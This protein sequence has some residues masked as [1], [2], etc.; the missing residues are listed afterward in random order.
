MPWFLLFI[1]CVCEHASI[2]NL[3]SDVSSSDTR[4]APFMSDGADH[5][6]RRRGPYPKGVQRRQEILERTLDVFAERGFSGTSLRA[7]GE[8]IGVSH[9]ALGHYFDSREALLVEVLRE[10]E[11]RGLEQVGPGLEVFDRMVK[12]A[13]LNADI[14]GIIALH[15]TL[16]GTAVEPGDEVARDFFAERFRRARSELAAELEAEL[17]SRGHVSDVDLRQLA[18]LIFAAFDGLQIQWLL[19]PTIDIGDTLRLLERLVR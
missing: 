10:R 11:R 2:Q 5:E 9:A 6:D 7:I 12:T 4:Y 13:R 14:P 19:D 8:A 18:S 17:A 1:E 16:M 3:Q 15:T